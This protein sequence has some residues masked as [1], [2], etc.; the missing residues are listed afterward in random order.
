M[1]HNARIQSALEDLGSQKKPNI[2]ATAKKWEIAR[3]TLSDRFHDKSTTIQE[4]NSSIRQQLSEAQEESLI[5]YINKI[6]DRG[7][8][9]T[10]QIVKNITESIVRTELGH[11]WTTRFVK[12][13]HNRLKS[14]YLRT[15]DHKRKIANNSQYFEHFYQ[16]VCINIS[17][18]LYDNN[19]F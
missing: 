18:L 19:I 10:S 7:L 13:H 8:H 17:F 9:P 6:S 12:R 2:T 11:N 16:N 5:E 1:D 14:V 3:K 15:I 4:V